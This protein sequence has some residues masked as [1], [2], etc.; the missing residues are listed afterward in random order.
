LDYHHIILFSD[1]YDNIDSINKQANHD[2][3][4]YYG[5][6]IGCDKVWLKKVLDR[7]ENFKEILVIKD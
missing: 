7:L 1:F 2:G 6:A 5:V 4:K 3:T